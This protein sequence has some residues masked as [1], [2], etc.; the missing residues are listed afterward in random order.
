MEE[1]PK[2]RRKNTMSASVS[3]AAK[4][5]FT[6]ICGIVDAARIRFAN[7]AN[8]EIVLEYW[9]I[10]TRIN[11][12]V[13]FGHRARYGDKT[14]ERLS[15]DLCRH[16]A[17]REFNLRNLRR[18]M[19]FAQEFPRIEIVS[20]VATQLSW[21]HIVEILPIRDGLQ[22][23]FYLTLAAT[24]RWGRD[25]LRN[26]I[27]GMLFERTEISGKPD[28]FIR[29]ELSD[30]QSGRPLN[31]ELVFKDP[32]FLDFTGLKGF[33]SERDL[34]EV[35]ISGI[36]SFLLELGTGFAFLARQKHMIIDGEDY[37]LD[38][39][40][41]H[42]TLRRLVA[43]ELKKGRFRAAYKGQMELYLRW[44]DKYER[45]HGEESPLGLILCADGADEQIELLQLGDSGIRVARYLTEL[46]DRKV[47]REQLRRQIESAR[48]RLL[49]HQPTGNPSRPQ[50]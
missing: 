25:E 3:R 40:F 46:P 21:S 14:V 38:L 24:Q 30:V 2:K 35:L 1:F 19:Q 43:V 15:I 39:L 22:R 9:S 48:S 8:A 36:Q 4:G 10:G 5:L 26:K 6:D 33:Y 18:M 37:F 29:K 47:L 28:D 17:T 44:L 20:R 13:L 49:L 34:E 32:Y 7:S 16:Y 41:Y 11:K 31:P 45:Q 27:D 23:D 50:P 42:R 12:E